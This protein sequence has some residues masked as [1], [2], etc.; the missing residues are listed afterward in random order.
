MI[1]AKVNVSI[2]LPP[3]YVA[4][5]YERMIKFGAN[6]CMKIEDDEKD[7]VN[8]FIYIYIII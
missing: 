5:T 7:R 8:S 1:C 6:I 2:E 3:K 4:V